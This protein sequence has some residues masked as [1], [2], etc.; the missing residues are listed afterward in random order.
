M[1]TKTYRF[2]SGDGGAGGYIS[3]P[4]TGRDPQIV[5]EELERIHAARGVLRPAVV[6]DEARPEDAPLHP[7][8]EWR[9]DV[10]AERFRREQAR[11]II[12]SVHVVAQ[13][14]EQG[15]APVVTRAFVSVDTNED[16]RFEPVA[17]VLNDAVLYAQVCRRACAELE[18]FQ[19]RYA[20][21]ASLKSIGKKATDEA[22][23]ELAVAISRAE[24]AA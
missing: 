13:P 22:Q 9:D 12:R 7:Y 10:A 4:T 24:T 6:V 8:F 2:R 11:A 16:A 1:S 15:A 18:A 3:T 19:E 14:D 5:G 17:T 23:A 21:F 20:Q